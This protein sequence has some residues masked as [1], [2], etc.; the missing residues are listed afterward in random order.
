MEKIKI[1]IVNCKEEIL[2]KLVSSDEIFAIIYYRDSNGEQISRSPDMLF[3]LM[4]EHIWNVKLKVLNVIG[5]STA[6]GN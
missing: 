2:L 6:H 3:W 4:V 1:L 5:T